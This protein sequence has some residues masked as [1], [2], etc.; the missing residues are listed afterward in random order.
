MKAVY[1]MLPSWLKREP[2]LEEIAWR[3]IHDCAKGPTQFTEF[4]TYVE[5]LEAIGCNQ[6]E[7]RHITDGVYNDLRLAE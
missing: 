7:I 6:D 4:G 5:V 1:E 3:V 2:E